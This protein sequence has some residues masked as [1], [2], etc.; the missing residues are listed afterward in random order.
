MHPGP[1]PPDF[2]LENKF[3]K[4]IIPYHFA[5]RPLSFLKILP[6]FDAFGNIT[7]GPSVSE[8]YL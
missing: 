6:G 5:F 3:E 4:S 8:K 1:G 7:A 2:P